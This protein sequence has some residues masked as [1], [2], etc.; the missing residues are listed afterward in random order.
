MAEAFTKSALD[1][2]KFDAAMRNVGAAADAAGFSFEETT[3]L[4]GILVDSGIE[5]S[6][7]GTDLRKIFTEISRKGITLDEALQNI[8]ESE[9]KVSDSFDEFGQRAL[10]AGIILSKNIERHKEF[11]GE[12]ED[13]NKEIQKMVD[14][15]G[16]ISFLSS[17][18]SNISSVLFTNYIN[19]I[20]TFNNSLYIY[21]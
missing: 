2:E 9:N 15:I 21:S 7:A 20:L 8:V 10:V 18:G 6:K 16:L 14:L 11:T 1:L 13:N 12:L 4:L 19:Y 17:L 3:S 5:A